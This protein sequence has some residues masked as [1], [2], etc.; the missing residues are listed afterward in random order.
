MGSGKTYSNDE[1]QYIKENWEYKTDCELGKVLNRP[2]FKYN[3]INDMIIDFIK[4]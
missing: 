3:E 2:V 4:E 1:I